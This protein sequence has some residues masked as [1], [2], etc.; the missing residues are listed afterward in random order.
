MG[1]L[2]RAIW[3]HR[4]VHRGRAEPGLS[5]LQWVR[6]ERWDR[7]VCCNRGS[8]WGH[9]ASQQCSRAG[10]FQLPS[11][12]QH[13]CRLELHCCTNNSCYRHSIHKPRYH[14]GAVLLVSI[15]LTGWIKDTH[16]QGYT[17]LQSLVNAWLT[18]RYCVSVQSSKGCVGL[19]WLCEFS[20]H[21]CHALRL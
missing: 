10:L 17:E 16:F 7:A 9:R 3:W 20:G 18:E 5:Q 19:H 1:R 8:Q 21:V 13:S 12:Q 14:S 4:A 6:A 2:C 15:S 11:L